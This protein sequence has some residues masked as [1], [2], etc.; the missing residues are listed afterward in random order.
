MVIKITVKKAVSLCKC[1]QVFTNRF[2]HGCLNNWIV[3][4]GIVNGR[5]VRVYR[6]TSVNFVCSA[7]VC[8]YTTEDKAR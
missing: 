3:L 1:F 5:S 2:H 8:V 6:L 7:C 4:L